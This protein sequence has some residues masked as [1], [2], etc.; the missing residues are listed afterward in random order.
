MT[1]PI[2][3]LVEWA[4]AQASPWFAHNQS[5]RLLE[6][7]VRANIE[8]RDL[9]APPGSCADGAAY[10]VDTGA[11]GAWAGHDGELA[12]AVGANA[13][14]GWL[15]A[16]VQHEGFTLWVEDEGVTIEWQADGSPAGWAEVAGGGVGLPTLVGNAL[17]VLRVKEDETGLEWFTPVQHVFLA[18]QATYDALPTK[19]E[20][21]LY[22]IPEE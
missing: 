7:L 12:V 18:D 10:L 2:F 15:F 13:S 5:I 8:D 9:A 3:A 11:T 16:D 22:Y 17:K 19:D 14:G 1:T 20:N 4:A 6:A 21:T